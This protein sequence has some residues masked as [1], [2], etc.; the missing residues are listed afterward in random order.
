MPQSPAFTHL[1]PK[2][3]G[4][5]TLSQVSRF[6]CFSGCPNRSWVAKQHLTIT[7]TFCA[8]L[9]LIRKLPQDLFTTPEIA[10][11]RLLLFQKPIPIN[12]LL[13]QNLPLRILQYSENCPQ[14]FTIIPEAYPYQL[15]ITPK[16]A[17]NQLSIKYSEMCTHDQFINYS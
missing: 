12:Y 14:S 13:L 15:F 5:R 16:S 7:S 1:S 17:P 3:L 4:P 9:L 6:P 11:S 10:P 2:G 8:R